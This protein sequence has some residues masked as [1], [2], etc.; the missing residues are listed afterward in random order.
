MIYLLGG[1]F[2]LAAGCYAYWQEV[3]FLGAPVALVAIVLLIQ[4]PQYLFY[5][6]MLSIPWS[7]E[8]SFDSNF[9]TDLPD[10]PLMLLAALSIVIYIAYK[11]NI[12]WVRKLHPLIIIILLLTLYNTQLESSRLIRLKIPSYCLPASSNILYKGIIQL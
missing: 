12:K 11:K 1:I 7:V 10:E 9:G 3:Y 4:H 5:L 8:Y 2:L 6:L